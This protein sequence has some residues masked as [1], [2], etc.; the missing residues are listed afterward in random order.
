[1]VKRYSLAG[2]IGGRWIERDLDRGR[3][4]DLSRN[5]GRNAEQQRQRWSGVVE[6]AKRWG[7]RERERRRGVEKCE[8]SSPAFP[9]TPIMHEKSEQR[10]A[11]L[12]DGNEPLKVES[13]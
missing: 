6:R 3:A 2:T 12:L 8:C 7:Q 11:L 5:Y 13:P 10:A 9:S 1:M 4:A